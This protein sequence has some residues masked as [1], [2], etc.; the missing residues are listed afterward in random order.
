[1]ELLV[2]QQDGGGQETE[3]L[4]A[5]RGGRTVSSANILKRCQGVPLEPESLTLPRTKA[6]ERR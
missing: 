2:D 4:D 1:M 6:K 3:I 5:P